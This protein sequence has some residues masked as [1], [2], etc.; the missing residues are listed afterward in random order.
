[1]SEQAEFL[2]SRTKSGV[3]VDWQWEIAGRPTGPSGS[4]VLT[5]DDTAIDEG[6]GFAGEISVYPPDRSDRS[7][8]GMAR[9]VGPFPN[10]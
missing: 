9:R 4:G 2:D 5:E 7:L 10:P 6:P 1:M 8:P 3:A